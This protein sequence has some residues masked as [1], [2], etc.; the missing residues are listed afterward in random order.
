VRR[1]FGELRFVSEAGY[2]NSSVSAGVSHMDDHT[3]LTDLMVQADAA[4]YAAK[5]SGRDRVVV[6]SNKMDAA[7]LV[8]AGTPVEL[9]AAATLG[10]SGRRDSAAR[11]GET[12]RFRSTR[13]GR[14]LR[15]V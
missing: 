10:L 8:A 9:E 15:R 12:E 11:N 5:R 3:Q 13:K 4:L 7:P 1:H 14:L 2:F 6:Y